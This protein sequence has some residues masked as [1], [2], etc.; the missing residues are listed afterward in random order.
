MGNVMF[1]I[2]AVLASAATLMVQVQGLPARGEPAAAASPPLTYELQI[3]GETFQVEAN[4]ETTLDSKKKPGVRY[5]VAL[6][7]APTQRIRLNSVVF[8][9]DLPAKV[10]DDGKRENRSVRITHELGFSALLTDLGRPLDAKEQKD[11]LKVLVDSVTAALGEMK[12]EGVKVTDPHERSFGGSSGRGIT[13]R[14][15]DAKGFTHVYLLYI[16]TGPKHAA[17]CVIKYLE[18]DGDDALPLVRKLL[19]SVRAT[20]ERR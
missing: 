4:R 18:N 3:D 20:P 7:V 13:I 1:R 17:T 8:D 15:R 12:A 5:R 11:A 10:Q 6:R 2:V 9:Y 19:D 16:L 14:Y